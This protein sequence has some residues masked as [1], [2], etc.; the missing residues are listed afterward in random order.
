MI[1]NNRLYIRSKQRDLRRFSSM[2][3]SSFLKA[4]TALN[5]QNVR[6]IWIE[7]F[8]VAPEL[9]EDLV[10]LTLE[11]RDNLIKFFQSDGHIEESCNTL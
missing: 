9:A 1:W 10:L 2:I 11:R 3:Y 8:D 5:Y 4:I 6:A 7:L